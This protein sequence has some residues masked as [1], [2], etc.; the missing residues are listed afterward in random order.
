MKKV[1]IVSYNFP[2]VGGAGVQRP[3]KFVKYLRDFCWEPVVMSVKNPSVPVL[4]TSLLSD[5]PRDVMIYRA[6]TV[7][8]SYI[9]KQK[10]VSKS[11]AKF[12][13]MFLLKKIISHLLLPD[14]QVLWWPGL[15][16]KLGV[17]IIQQKPVCI[18]VSAPPFSSFIPVV[19]LGKIFR[20][21]IVLDYRDEWAFS[22][23]NWENLN[24]SRFAFYLDFVLERFVL[25]NCHAFTT[26]TTSYINNIATLYGKD[27]LNKGF[28]ITNGYDADDFFC[29]NKP[30]ICKYNAEQIDIVYVGTVWSATSLRDFCAVLKKLMLNNPCY[31][32]TLRITICG[33]VVASECH[34]LEDDDLREIVNCHGYIE[35]EKAVIEMCNADILLITLSDLPGADKII[36]GKVF[37]YMAS[38]K[39][40]FAM[41]PVGE[42]Q[43][44]LEINYNNKTIVF[45]KEHAVAHKKLEELIKNI[46]KI[47]LVKGSDVSRFERKNTT[48]LLSDV[49][50][51][52]TRTSL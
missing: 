39:H 27:L 9:A 11:K 23:N 42:T 22:R 7:E 52:V 33:R 19:I 31:K 49:F 16:W 43:N 26:A 36:T 34:Y 3:V 29:I 4:D 24:K 13:F 10:I 40:I 41:V 5:I 15:L 35:H 46:D 14:L 47:R 12:S 25:K 2:P 44:I 32:K 37:E 18:F 45:P 50:D 21:P 1:L 20:I 51:N 28:V 6:K 17:A 48:K 30:F 38:G 8:P